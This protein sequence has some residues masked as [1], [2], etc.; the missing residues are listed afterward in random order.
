MDMSSLIPQL[1]IS[2]NSRCQKSCFYC[3]PSGESSNEDI[4]R[5][6]QLDE[7]FSIIEKIA[8]FGVTNVKLT[9]GD[10]ILYP[11]II[12][13]IKRI[14]SIESVTQIDLITRHPKVAQFANE[15]NQAGL[16]CLNF[17]LDTLNKNKYE[18]ITGVNELDEFID[19]IKFSI[20]NSKSTKIN[21][22][23]MNGINDDEMMDMIIFCEKIGIQTLKFLDL[24]LGISQPS[25]SC[26]ERLR[27]L[28]SK[29]KDVDELYFPL[30]NYVDKLIPIS[31]SFEITYQSGGLGHPMDTFILP[32]GLTIQI[33]DARKGA[34]YGKICNDCSL[35]PCHDALM[36]LRLTPDGRLQKCLAREDNLV[37]IYKI[38]KMN[39][40]EFETEIL[41]DVFTTYSTAHFESNSRIEAQKQF[42]L[43]SKG[44]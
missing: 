26:S 16:D 39:D 18:N 33:K 32:S 19:A 5:E 14:R 23:V 9:G 4:T 40:I 20:P 41:K 36:A 42:P 38:L 21:T 28:S 3:R 27:S 12:E 10:P 13:L 8:G 11:K 31:K 29:N 15:L 43:R 6:I 2:V 30:N 24:I 44:Q 35:Y 7:L 25:N 17:S 34:W 37:D 22:V 1:R